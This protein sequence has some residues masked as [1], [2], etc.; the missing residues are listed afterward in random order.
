MRIFLLAAALIAGLAPAGAVAADTLTKV[1]ESGTFVIGYRA[2]ARPFS[3]ANEAGEP[4]GFSVDLCRRISDAVK[5]AIGDDA[6]KTE[7]V[8]VGAED[9]LDKVVDGTVDIECGSTTVTLGRR[10]QVSFT[11]M[12]FVTGAEMLV[13]VDSGLG[14]LPDL[15]GRAVGVLG[16]TTTETGLRAALKQQQIDADVRTFERHENGLAALEN[17]EIDAYFADRILLMGLE[18]KATAAD[19]LALSGR[20]YSYEPYA[21]TIRRGDEAFRLVA[22]STLAGLYR[23][24]AIWDIYDKHLPGAQPSELLVALYILQGLPVK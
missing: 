20:F 19:K 23:S 14:D 9:R 10:E 11:L 3:Y 22:D 7:F 13:R 21:L 5:Q 24:G 17:A 4:A 12:T 1:K 6:L 16:G 18:Q 15:K 8:Q 2:D